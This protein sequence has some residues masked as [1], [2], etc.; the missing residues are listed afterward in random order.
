MEIGSL[1]ESQLKI[2]RLCVSQMSP[3]INHHLKQRLTLLMAQL[4]ELR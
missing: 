3:H 4:S 2:S 1:A